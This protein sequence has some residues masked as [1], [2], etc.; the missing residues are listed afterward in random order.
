MQLVAQYLHRLTARDAKRRSGTDPAARCRDK[1]RARDPG[2]PRRRN[3]DGAQSGGDGGP[4][5]AAGFEVAGE[6]L[7]VAAAGTENVQMVLVAP[8]RV[9][10]Q[11]PVSISDRMAPHAARPAD[12]RRAGRPSYR[13]SQAVADRGPGRTRRPLA[14]DPGQAIHCSDR[15]TT[16]G[17]PD[18]VADDNRG[19]D[20]PRYRLAAA[21]DRA[22]SRLRLTLRVLAR[23]QAPLRPRTGAIPLPVTSRSRCCHG[24]ELRQF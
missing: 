17:V 8:A 1:L 3:G 2:R 12:R 9:L 20:A 7:D 6:A 24:R 15:A 11:V 19:P 22:A 4:G 5:A 21:Q 16:D 23:L 18:L 14:R 13:P 10:A